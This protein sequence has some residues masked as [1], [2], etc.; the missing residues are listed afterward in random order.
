MI[1]KALVCLIAILA[2]TPSARP[3]DGKPE[4][5]RLD[6]TGPYRVV[7]NWFKPGVDGWNQ[8]VTGVAVD[9]PNRIFVVS[10]GQQITQPGS[11]ILDPDGMAWYTDFG[12]QVLGK[13]DPKSGKVTEYQVPT[14]KPEFPPGL[15]DIEIDKKGVVWVSLA[16]GHLGSFDRRKCKVLRGPTATGPPTV[17]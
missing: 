9:N 16:S 13:L 3:Q 15:L 5:D 14:L 8:P 12:H 4:I 11:L 2:L 1:R 17:P 10:S 7:E 6:T